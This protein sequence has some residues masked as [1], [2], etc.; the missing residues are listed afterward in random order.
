MFLEF[1]AFFALSTALLSIQWAFLSRR[2]RGINRLLEE[3]RPG[4]FV[5]AVEGELR[6]TSHPEMRA[7]LTISRSAGLAYLGRWTE[8]VDDLES[9]D[10]ELLRQPEARA[11]YFN[12]LLY[13]LLLAGRFER[14][15]QIVSEQTRWLV[16]EYRHKELNLSL[17]G[18]M[19]AFYYFQGDEEEARKELEMLESQD[20]GRLPR[21][22]TLYFLARLDLHQG[23]TERGIARLDEISRT[24][25]ESCFAEEVQRLPAGEERIA[26]PG[27]FS[28]V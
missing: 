21:A 5:E 14:A 6:R 3:G 12:N 18:T 25:S 28:V 24:A 17:R 22:A 4:A 27:A 16:P 1:L 15:R 10:H 19:A 11:V 9:L 13:S 7:L 26:G 8:A 20:R 2:W 23:H